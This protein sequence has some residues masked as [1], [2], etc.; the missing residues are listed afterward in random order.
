MKTFSFRSVVLR[1][2]SAHTDCDV[3]INLLVSLCT[4][5]LVVLAFVQSC[6]RMLRKPILIKTVHELLWATCMQK[7]DEMAKPG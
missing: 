6:D 2:L 4:C 7:C 5:E 3:K 1:M